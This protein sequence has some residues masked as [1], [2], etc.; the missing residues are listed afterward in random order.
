MAVR[1]NYFQRYNIY[2]AF[3][4]WLPLAAFVVLPTTFTSLKTSDTLGDSKTGKVVQD[5]IQNIPILGISA[6][7]CTLGTMGSYWLW[8]KMNDNYI[9][10]ITHIFM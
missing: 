10:I 1:A 6:A 4:A 7:F 8:T 9:W 2:A 3:F 5:S